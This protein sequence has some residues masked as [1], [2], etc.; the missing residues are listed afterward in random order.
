MTGKA[1]ATGKKA[2]LELGEAAL[3]RSW[4]VGSGK[5]SIATAK[6]M[7]GRVRRLSAILDV[8]TPR[9]E[10]YWKWVE[11]ELSRGK[12][13]KSVAND[14]C[15][16]AAWF[17]FKG[18]QMQLPRLRQRRA[19]EPWV[20]DENAVLAMLAR[21][22]RRADRAAAARDRAMIDLFA[23]GGIRLGELVQLNL[24]DLRDGLLHV[25]SEKREKE[26]MIGLPDFVMNDISRYITTYRIETSNALFTTK[27]G[28]V[29][30]DYI[31]KI[32]KTEGERAGAPNMHPHAL[33]HFCG[34]ALVN[35]GVN[36]RAVQMHLGHASISTTQIYTHLKETK[37][38]EVVASAFEE[39]FRR[40]TETDAFAPKVAYAFAGDNL[41][42]AGVGI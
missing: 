13:E 17:A 12:K 20:P 7:A 38:A 26:R 36:L 6:R 31:R 27:K 30:Y 11:H 22:E 21:Q 35:A 33:R 5:Y 41:P 8:F 29:T 25:R 23:F 42:G 32:I 14:I 40:E 10:E 4:A 37:V 34:T 1:A 39:C 28:R 19:P 15:D 9:V 24:D 18:I 2:I 16:L 3:F